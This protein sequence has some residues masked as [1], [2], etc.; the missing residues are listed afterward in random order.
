MRQGFFTREEV[1]ELCA[2]CDCTQAT[3]KARFWH[4]KKAA[5]HPEVTACWH[6]PPD[7]ADMVSFLFWSAWRVGEARE[8][9]WRD[10]DRMEQAIRL[11]PEHSKN[12]H[13]R[14]LPVEGELATIIGRRWRARRLDCPYVF[15][16]TGKRI[17]DFR[18]V[19]NRAC[20]AIGLEGRIVHD[21]RRS[22]V[23][24]LIRAGV[25]PHTV[26][27]MSG[28]RTA[29]MLKRYDIISLDDLRLAARQGSDYTGQRSQVTPLRQRNP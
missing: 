27:A 25:P 2:V 28:H 6:L 24:H 1:E 10:Y 19:W 4:Q 21:L 29:S 12:K 17:R 16:R 7:L 22:G 9:H 20:K 3:I 18:K 14:V 13:G 26:M 5:E 23:R 8:L 15:H 11:R